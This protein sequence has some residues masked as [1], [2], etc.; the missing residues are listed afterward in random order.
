MTSSCVYGSFGFGLVLGGLTSFAGLN[1][2]HFRLTQKLKKFRRI[3]NSFVQVVAEIGRLLRKRSM[4]SISTS[5]SFVIPAALVVAMK[6]SSARRWFRFAV[7][8]VFFR[9]LESLDSILDGLGLLVVWLFEFSKFTVCLVQIS[10][11]K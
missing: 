3:A 10:C 7:A 6:L 8:D 1:E 5:S 9:G 11:F 4:V 2:I